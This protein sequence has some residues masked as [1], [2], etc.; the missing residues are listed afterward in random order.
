MR[1]SKQT[2]MTLV[3]VLVVLAMVAILAGTTVAALGGSERHSGV[4]AEAQR[5]AN[6]LNLAADEAL[7]TA[8]PLVLYWDER[9][10]RFDSWNT[11]EGEWQ[12]YA[13]A[14]LGRPHRLP[15]ELRLSAEKR[16]N[17]AQPQR[18]AI[19]PGGASDPFLMTIAGASRDWRV[20][21]DGLT[22]STLAPEE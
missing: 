5:L 18:F 12:P 11:A 2:G 3:E 6:R 8:A 4:A 20:V 15:S 17:Q 1:I 22:A 21:F 19:S 13:V 10:Y 16:A 9:S 14:L 7:V